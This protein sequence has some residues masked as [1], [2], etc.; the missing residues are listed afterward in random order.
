MSHYLK[1]ICDL[2]FG[3]ENFRNELIWKR[4]SAHSSAHRY[5][6]VHDTLLFYTKS[7]SFTWNQLYTPFE[8]EYVETFF[9]SQG[10]DGKLYKRMD[11]TG[12][13][14]TKGESGLPWRGID[15][16]SR[17]RHWAYVH[18]TLDDFDSKGRIHWPKKEGGMPRLIQYPEDLDGVPLQDVWTDIRP[19]HNLSTERLKYPTQKPLQL[20]DRIIQ[21]STNKGDLVL[22]AFC[23]CGT[24]VDSAEHLGRRWIGIDISPVAV[25]LI[26]WR[27]EETYKRTLSKFEVRGIPTDDQSA[28]ELWRQNPNAFQDWW[29]VEHEALSP[30]FGT[31]GSDGGRDGIIAMYDLGSNG[32]TMRVAFQVKGGGS[33][34]QRHGCTS[35]DYDQIRLQ[36]GSFS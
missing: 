16:T 15:V 12:A 33:A 32:G 10:K 28:I 13:G 9:D 34:I 7:D 24:A 1:T 5:G 8:A 6:S 19:I 11:L 22:D 2:I 17:G 3:H 23:G 4:T 18:K 21:A 30:T 36:D 27:L 14:T 35:W 31:K 20:L 29:I 25:G 26:R